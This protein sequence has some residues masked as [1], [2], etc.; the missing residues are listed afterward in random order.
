MSGMHNK[1]LEQFF[2]NEYI[3]SEIIVK[4]V[5]IDLEIKESKFIKIIE[6]VDDRMLNIIKDSLYKLYIKKD[7]EIYNAFQIIDAI[8]TVRK[9]RRE[10]SLMGLTYS[11]MKLKFDLTLPPLR[12]KK[13]C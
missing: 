7:G 6:N 11:G 10:P 3:N 12:R 9:L 4:Y 1:K 5:A 2:L 8:D 13:Y